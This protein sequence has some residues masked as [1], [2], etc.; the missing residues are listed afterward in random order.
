MRSTKA[1]LRGPQAYNV[2]HPAKTLVPGLRSFTRAPDRGYA[3]FEAVIR[4]F[5]AGAVEIGKERSR[6]WKEP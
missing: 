1:L 3:C 6:G 2:I 5:L 4:F